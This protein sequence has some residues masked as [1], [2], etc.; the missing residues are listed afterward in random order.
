MKNLWLKIAGGALVILALVV[1]ISVFSSPKTP[2]D[3]VELTPEQQAQKAEQRKQNRLEKIKKRQQQEQTTDQTRDIAVRREVRREEP[4]EYVR[5]EQL[6][7]MVVV[8]SKIAKK[9]MM[10][11]RRMVDYCRQLFKEYPDSS[12]AEKARELLR[13]MPPRDKRRYKI[14]N[15]ELGL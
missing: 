5:A 4:E 1:L 15:E 12:Q 13:Q 9:P 2:K 6:Y 10:T 7:Q 11:Y 8:E 3:D 14:T